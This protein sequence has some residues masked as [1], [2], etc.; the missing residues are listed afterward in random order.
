MAFHEQHAGVVSLVPKRVEKV[1]TV[2]VVTHRD[3]NWRLPEQREL[4]RELIVFVR[5]SHMHAIPVQNH[6]RR[7]LPHG[8]HLH[9]SQ[10]EVFRHDGRSPLPGDL[11]RSI[12]LLDG[13]RREQVRV[14]QQDPRI[15]ICCRLFARQSGMSEGREGC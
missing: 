10:V 1:T 6:S 13:S 3:M 5:A 4:A 7:L 11:V 9:R 14:G 8:V 12:V 2:V 15:R